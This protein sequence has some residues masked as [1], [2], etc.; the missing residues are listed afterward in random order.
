[1]KITPEF[2][3]KQIEDNFAFLSVMSV[4]EY[5][6]YRKWMEINRMDLDVNEVRS[7]KKIRDNIWIPKSP[8]DYE[9]LNIKVIYAD[10]NEKLF[11]WRMLRTFISTAVWNANPGR[12]LRFYVVHETEEENILSEIIKVQKYL[13]VISIGSDFI[14]VGGRDKTIGWTQDHKLD[15]GMLRHTAMGSSIVPTQPMG[16]NYLGGK[17]ISLLVSSNVVENVWNEKYKD[18]LAGVTTTSLYGGFSQYNNLSYWKKCDSTQGLVDLEPSEETFEMMREFCKEHYPEDYTEFYRVEKEDDGSICNVPSHPKTR[19]MTKI[20][21]ELNINTPRNNAPRGVYW[22]PLYENTNEFLRKQDNVL[23]KKK[24][25]NTV[26]TLSLLWKDKYAKKRI[27]KLIEEERLS[28][29]I[30][31]YFDIKGLTW[32]ETKEKYL[33]EVGR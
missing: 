15:G 22:C 17:L 25:D 2:M 28:S 18:T 1:M 4:P 9:N 7:I 12:N 11:T 29:G 13:G 14:S 21:K 26:E 27:E 23:G 3:K 19:L 6:L 16:Y 30:L 8:K 5:T 10:N 33:E 32:E 31:F 24:F 20:F